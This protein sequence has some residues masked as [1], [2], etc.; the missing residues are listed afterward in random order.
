MSSISYIISINN[1]VIHDGNKPIFENV[2]K[3]EAAHRNIILLDRLKSVLPKKFSGFL[4]SMDGD[5]ARPLTKGAFD[6]RWKSYCKKYNISITAHQ[7]RHGFATMLF[8]AGIDLKDAQDLMGH[9]DINLT[10]SV[11][12]HIR[13]KRKAE[14]A[15]KLNAFIF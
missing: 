3:S 12:T 9:S 13:D 8:E 1:H 15:D 6:K 10:R 5:G 2:L 11:Y 7:L 4:F 14:T